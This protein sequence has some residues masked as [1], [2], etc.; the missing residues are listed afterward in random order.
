MVRVL[1]QFDARNGAILKHTDR[2]F[3]IKI[4]KKRDEIH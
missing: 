3:H 2:E 4:V 1:Q